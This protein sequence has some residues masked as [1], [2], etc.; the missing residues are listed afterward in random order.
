MPD[1]TPKKKVPIDLDSLARAYT[2]QAI[3]TIGG[4]MINGTEE[5]NRL[6]A[7]DILLDRGWGRPKQQQTTTVQ[8]GL[9]LIIRDIAAEKAKKKI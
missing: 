3:Q 9:D 5:A 4:V 6:R 8:G 7:A 1:P 2:Q